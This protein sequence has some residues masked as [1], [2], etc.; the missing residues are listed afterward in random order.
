M[1]KAAIVS[2]VNLSCSDVIMRGKDT[3]RIILSV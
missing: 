3:T 1:K 2:F